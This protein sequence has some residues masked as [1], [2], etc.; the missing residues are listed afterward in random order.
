M[1]PVELRIAMMTY[2]GLPSSVNT[3]GLP[4]TGLRERSNK[5]SHPKVAMINR[6]A[7]IMYI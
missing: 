6:I 5:C 4:V 7:A 3:T 1:A 2:S